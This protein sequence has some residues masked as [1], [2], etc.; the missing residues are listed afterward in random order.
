MQL[1]KG[2]DKNMQLC[3]YFI[4]L[5]INQEFRPVESIA[6]P[7]GRGSKLFRCNPA[8]RHAAPTVQ[9]IGRAG[10]WLDDVPMAC[11]MAY[12]GLWE[13]IQWQSTLSVCA[14]WPTIAKKQKKPPWRWLEYGDCR[15]SKYSNSSKT[16]S[17]IFKMLLKPRKYG[18]N[19]SPLFGIFLSVETTWKHSKIVVKSCNSNELWL[20]IFS[21]LQLVSSGFN[22]FPLNHSSRIQKT[23]RLKRVTLAVESLLHW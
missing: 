6:V 11:I 17:K 2:T 10:N 16:Y 13:A 18:D 22:W 3:T 5:W 15:L 20:F 21:P 19:S 8:G 12:D 23:W 4:S 14:T 7:H 9:S 1:G